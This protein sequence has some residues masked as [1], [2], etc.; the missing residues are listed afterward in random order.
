MGYHGSN[1]IQTPNIDALA[2][3]G[4][5]LDKFYVNPLCTPSRAALMTGK[6]PIR[7]GDR[8]IIEISPYSGEEELTRIDN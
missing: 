1:A 6:Y 2:Y 4:I 3:D 7:T 8:Q 5:I